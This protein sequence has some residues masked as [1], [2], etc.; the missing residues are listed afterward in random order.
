MND[1]LYTPIL[2]QSELFYAWFAGNTYYTREVYLSKSTAPVG[3]E[4]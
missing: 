2:Q 4:I 3:I 1:I